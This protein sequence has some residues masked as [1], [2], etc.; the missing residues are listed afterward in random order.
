MTLGNPAVYVRSQAGASLTEACTHGLP[1]LG[2]SCT[3]KKRPAQ[4]KWGCPALLLLLHASIL[5]CAIISGRFLRIIIVMISTCPSA[6]GCR[7]NESGWEFVAHAQSE[8]GALCWQAVYLSEHPGM[9]LLMWSQDGG[10]RQAAWCA[11]RSAL[12]SVLLFRFC[13]R[14]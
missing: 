13:V 9:C 8:T 10:R 4:V 1:V 14:I 6:L 2:R 7:S 11:A 3:Q 12:L 5:L